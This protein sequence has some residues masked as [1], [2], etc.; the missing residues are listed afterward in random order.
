VL[1]PNSP[2][3]REHHVAIRVRANEKVDENTT[4]D[5]KLDMEQYKKEHPKVQFAALDIVHPEY[6]TYPKLFFFPDD[7]YDYVAY[8]N[9]GASFR[10]TF[11]I[12]MT[13]EKSPATEDELAAYTKVLKS[14]HAFPVTAR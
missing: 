3:S 10:F 8:V 12:S 5:L 7:F 4:E 9:P 1:F 14:L 6:K 11:S 13:K 2:Q